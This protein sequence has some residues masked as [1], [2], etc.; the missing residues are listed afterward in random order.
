MPFGD[1]AWRL[2]PDSIEGSAVGGTTLRRTGPNF[3][4]HLAERPA[5]NSGS[6]HPAIEWPRESPLRAERRYCLS[7][8]SPS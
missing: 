7:Q 4:V 1:A 3:L 5:D 2:R 6:A 8:E